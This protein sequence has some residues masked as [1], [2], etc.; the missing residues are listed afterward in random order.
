MMKSC[1]STLPS[2]AASSP[3]AHVSIQ[4]A[5]EKGKRANPGTQSHTLGTSAKHRHHYTRTKSPK[6][7]RH[8]RHQGQTTHSTAARCNPQPD[9]NHDQ[10]EKKSNSLCTKTHQIRNSR[11]KQEEG[12]GCCRNQPRRLRQIGPATI[13]A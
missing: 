12:V 4:Q 13:K 7:G 3:L 1:A 9:C 11:A 8:Q 10:H 5:A 6:G 2:R